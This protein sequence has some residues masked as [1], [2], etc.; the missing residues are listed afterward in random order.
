VKE[1]MIC[2]CFHYTKNDIV[3][4]YFDHG[5][6]TILEQ[7]KGGKMLGNCQCGI[8]NPKGK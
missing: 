4:D 7:I 1:K 3:R 2:Y 8:K 6:S 5:Y